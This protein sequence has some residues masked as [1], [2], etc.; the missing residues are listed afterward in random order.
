MQACS[1]HQVKAGEFPPLPAQFLQD[2]RNAVRYASRRNPLV[3]RNRLVT[4]YK[5]AAKYFELNVES[6]TYLS[7]V[8]TF[9]AALDVLTGLPGEAGTL[10]KIQDGIRYTKSLPRVQIFMPPIGM[11]FI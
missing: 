1:V 11:S 10:V 4:L 3:G 9:R 7:P 6:A 8:A 5:T 2:V